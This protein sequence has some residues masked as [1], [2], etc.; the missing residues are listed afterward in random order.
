[1]RDLHGKIFNPGVEISAHQAQAG[2][3]FRHVSAHLI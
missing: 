1:M 3:K 2:L